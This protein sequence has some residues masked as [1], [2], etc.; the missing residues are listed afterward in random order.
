M[1][2]QPADSM[3]I[4]SY[5]RLNPYYADDDKASANPTPTSGNTVLVACLVIMG[6]A[7]AFVVIWS[8]G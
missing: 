6:V 8:R 5:V 3:N 4:D 7:A 1:S 2:Y